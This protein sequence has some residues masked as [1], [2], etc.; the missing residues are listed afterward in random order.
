MNYEYRPDYGG[1]FDEDDH[2]TTSGVMPWGKFAGTALCFVAENE[3]YCEFL[4][5]Q[6]WFDQWPRLRD[7]LMAEYACLQDE[8]KRQVEEARAARKKA[9][10]EWKQEQAE[11]SR[12]DLPIY[13]R[14]EAD[15]F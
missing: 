9:E 5:D 1:G 7:D 13:L 10:R 8:R 6:P 12:T 3:W 14:S 4:F 2:Y 11:K 15:E